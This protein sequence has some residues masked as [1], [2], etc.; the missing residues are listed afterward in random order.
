VAESR[1]TLL[2]GLNSPFGM[3]L[4]GNALYVADTDAVLRFPYREGETMITAP[5]VKI[6]DLPAG[7]LNH[8]WTKNLIP[9]PDGQRLYVTVG[10]NSNAAENG[11]EAERGRAAIWE[12]DLA[13]GTI[14]SSPRVCAIR[15]VWIGSA[16]PARCG[17]QSM[18][19]MRSAAI[20]C[21]TI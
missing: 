13:T 2:D 10:S 9:S 19:A 8:H 21:P 7:T 17:P 15:T 11:I 16:P 1:F 6:V 14:G 20:W 3:A 18:N 4:V 12:L 5:A